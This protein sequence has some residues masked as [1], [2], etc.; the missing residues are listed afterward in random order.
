MKHIHF[1]EINSTNTYLK[2]NYSNYENLTV[3]SAEHQTNGKGRFNRKWIDNDDLLFSILIKENLVKITDYS[4]LIAKSIFNV[5]SKYMDNL[6]IKWPNDIMVNDNKICGILLEAVST[7]KIECVVLGVGINVNTT[8]FSEDLL[9][10]AT[11]MK[12]I[13]NRNINKEELLVEIM[14]CFEKDYNEYING[15]KDFISVINNNFYLKD[16]EVSFNYNNVI[17]SGKALGIN[18]YGEILIKVEDE[19]MNIYA[20]EVTFTNI[21]KK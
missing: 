17:Y 9:L 16:K 8:I 19:I 10:K 15:N 20:G 2:E 11:S 14:I 12:S 4:L 18:E 6:S 5:L 7:S 3:V 13:L 1:K 21:Y